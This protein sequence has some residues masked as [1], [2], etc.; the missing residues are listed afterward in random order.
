MQPVHS[1]ETAFVNEGT[2]ARGLPWHARPLI[3]LNNMPQA[4][5]QAGLYVDAILKKYR[6]RQKLEGRVGFGKPSRYAAFPVMKNEV[7]P[8]ALLS[9]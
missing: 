4:R 2:V 9:W 6:T 7:I 5:I 1:F 8:S 3:Q